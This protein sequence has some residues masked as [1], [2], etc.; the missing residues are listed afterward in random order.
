[1][2]EKPIEPAPEEKPDLAKELEIIKRQKEECLAGW[3][4]ARAD[5]INYKREE[6]ERL[7]LM[8]EYAKES[9]VEKLLPLMDNMEIAELRIPDDLK[10]NEYVQ[11]LLRVKSQIQDFFKS[12][13]VEAIDA[14]GKPFDPLVHEAVQEGK[15]EGVEA[16]IVIEVLEKGYTASG[17]LLRPAKVKVST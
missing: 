5:L 7:S 16:G 14:K 15:E 2:E 13:H 8:Q 10:Q 11:G 9:L 6:A 3:Q 4:R 17:K 1:M 12:Q